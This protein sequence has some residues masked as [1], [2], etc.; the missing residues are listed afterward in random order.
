MKQK[1]EGKTRAVQGRLEQAG[2]FGQ[3]GGE[4]SFRSTSRDVDL[5]EGSNILKGGK[6]PAGPVVGGNGASHGARDNG[7]PGEWCVKAP[8]IEPA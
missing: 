6:D 2:V 5:R 3:V 8:F 7:H 1:C 4:G